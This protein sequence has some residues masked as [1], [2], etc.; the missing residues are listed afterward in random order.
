MPRKATNIY[1]RKDGRWEGRYPIGKNPNGSVKYHSVYAKSYTEVKNK[2]MLASTTTKFQAPKT[3][4]L[5]SDLL[6]M[7]MNSNSLKQKAST[8]LKYE[9]LIEKHINPELGGYALQ[10][11]NG[12][13]INQFLENKLTIGR[14]DQTGGLSPSYVQTM[15]LIINSAI[16]F[17]IS[18][19]YCQRIKPPLLKPTLETKPIEI[20]NQKDQQ[21]LENT[22]LSD[23]SPINIGIL[24]T[25]NT[26]M[27]LGEICALQWKDIDLDNKVIHIRRSVIRVKNTDSTSSCKTM[28]ILDTP[29]TATSSRDIPITNKM[30]S[31]LSKANSDNQE[32]FVTSAKKTFIS[33]RTYEYQFKKRL[34]FCGLKKINYHAL[35][36]TFATR[37]IEKGVDVK[38][39]S[40][41]LGHANVN[42]TLNTYVHSSMEL[43]RQQLEK[44]L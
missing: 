20:L 1:K 12:V 33:P 28:L 26:G 13:I 8:K 25:L 24:L 9:S 42:I 21:S 44:L 17:G 4:L 3:K 34:D 31:I 41:I 37:C 5:F 6:E 2:L 14:I 15:Y 40:E 29:K 10:N 7:W 16:N 18:Q 38:T 22:L 19:E 43:K 32:A 39:L 35:R 36:H 11:L 30:L 27:R 23:L